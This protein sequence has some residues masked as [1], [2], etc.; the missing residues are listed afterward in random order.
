[1][2]LYTPKRIIFFVKK[3]LIFSTFYVYF[4][5]VR[6]NGKNEILYDLKNNHDPQK[7]V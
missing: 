5:F 4:I 2:K 6:Y 7:N 1:M 3:I